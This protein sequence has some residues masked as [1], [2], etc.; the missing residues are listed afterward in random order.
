MT[1]DKFQDKEKV[2]VLLKGNNHKNF[3]NI[4]ETDISALLNAFNHDHIVPEI[5]LNILINEMND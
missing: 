4:S 5:F 1:Y 3:I 2:P